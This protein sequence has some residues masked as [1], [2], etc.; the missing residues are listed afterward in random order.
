VTAAPALSTLERLAALPTTVV[1]DAL[2]RLGVAGGIHP[3]W[4]GARV[5]GPART[6]LT[7]SGD[8]LRVHEALESVMPGEVLVIDGGGDTTR[9]LVG[10][11]MAMRAVNAGAAGFV[12]DGAVRDRT[13]LEAMRFP[14]FARGVSPAGPYKHGPGHLDRPVAIGGVVVAP[15]D[16]II[17]DD[18][19]LVVVPSADA[20]AVCAR[21]EELAAAEEAKRQR[22]LKGRS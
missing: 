2:D 19:G 1:A 11:L 9:A 17:G 21:A 14:V 18:D 8:N 3:V 10:E 6:V 16:L 20:P 4:A 22:Y 7:R 13:A 15:G 5:A 12:V